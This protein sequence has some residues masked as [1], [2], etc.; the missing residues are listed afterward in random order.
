M[1]QANAVDLDAHAVEQEAFVG[2]EDGLADS[3]RRVA[4]VH[5]HALL[6]HRA[7][8]FVEIG[9]LYRP[10]A[11]LFHLHLLDELVFAVRRD[12]LAGLRRLDHSPI[13]VE[14][15]CGQRAPGGSFPFVDDPGL[16]L[17]GRNL[18]RDLGRCD[19]RAPLSNVDPVGDRQPGMPV[20]ARA[21]VPA[22]VGLV[23]V[24]HLDRE[25]VL[26]RAEV[27][28][29]GEVVPEADVSERPLA[30]VLAVDPHLAVLIDAVKFNQDLSALVA[31]GQAESFSVPADARG[32]VAPLSPGRLLLAV[33][34]LDAPVVREVQ[35]S[36]ACIREARVLRARGVALVEFPI[37]VEARPDSG[38]GRLAGR[39]RLGL[40]AVR[41]FQRRYEA[42]C[43]DCPSQH[44]AAA[45][46]ILPFSVVGHRISSSVGC[47]TMIAA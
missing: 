35:A 31:V 38:R 22:R 39:S 37:E 17:H 41:R 45:Q 15:A 18:R 19:E 11:G 32:Q 13:P 6:A 29:R 44:P 40:G 5:H 14:D 28:V 36:P 8:D 26:A 21:R 20:D 34:P 2:V 3:A 10:Q 12:V 47:A 7:A 23:G 46:R 1:M 24:V 9:V 43:A 27:D 30:E 33:W 4:L 16:D 25:H 42:G